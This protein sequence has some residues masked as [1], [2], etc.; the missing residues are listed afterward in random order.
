MTTSVLRQ[1]SLPDPF[2]DGL[3]RGWKVIGASTLAAD[4]T[5]EADVAIVGT[6]DGG[7][8]AAEILADA[9]LN[10]VMI[11]EGPL[12]TSSDFHMREAEAYP[13][14]YQESA[15]RQTRAKEINILK[16]R[17]VGAGSTATWTSRVRT[18]PRTRP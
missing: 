13:Q 12:Q 14:R 5:L 1:A 16:G 3:G 9:G 2:R 4:L 15:A 8:T 7:G 6:G 18:P 11:E 17:C 10:V